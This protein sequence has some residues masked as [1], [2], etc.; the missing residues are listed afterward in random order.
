MQLKKVIAEAVGTYI[1]VFCGTG[2]MV[3][4]NE[5]PGSVTG[6]G[7]ALTF[8]A[9]V[10]AMIYSFGEVSGA[11]INPAVT[12]AFWVSGK[13]PLKSVPIYV[14]S[15]FGGA[16]LASMTVSGLFP[17]SELLGN[18]LPAASEMQAFYFEIILTFILMLVIINVST[19][20]KEQGL[21]AGMAIGAVVMLEA[22]FAGPV[23][24]ASMNPARSIG[25]ALL[26]GEYRGI[27]L[28]M[29]AP[30]IGAVLAVLLWKYTNTK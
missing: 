2:A 10:M 8:G 18:T 20:S 23:T 3:I 7:I 12:I 17:D 1:L 29:L 30:M 19:G 26:S 21:M 25:P 13:F 16:I 27:W 4:N 24:G 11:H 9:T 15:Q 14:L 6:V 28:Y 5:F 22:A